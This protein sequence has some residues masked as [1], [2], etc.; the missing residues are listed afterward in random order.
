MSEIQ[1]D[2]GQTM[3]LTTDELLDI[4]QQIMAVLD[5]DDLGYLAKA[6]SVI[7]MTELVKRDLAPDHLLQDML[8]S[9]DFPEFKADITGMH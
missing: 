4:L 8:S 7:V 3:E 9:E 1:V 2:A 5:K 6:L